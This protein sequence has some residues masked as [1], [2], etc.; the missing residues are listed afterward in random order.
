MT[1]CGECVDIEDLEKTIGFS[2]EKTKSPVGTA[3]PYNVHLF[4]C[5]GNLVNFG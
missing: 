2:R 1:E 4:V 3:D 5:T